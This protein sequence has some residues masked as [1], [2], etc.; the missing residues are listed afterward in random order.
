M[1]SR[2][3]K[4]RMGQL[5]KFRSAALKSTMF[6]FSQASN[7]HFSETTAMLNAAAYVYILPS[8]NLATTNVVLIFASSRTLPPMWRTINISDFCKHIN[9]ECEWNVHQIHTMFLN[10]GAQGC[11][12]IISRHFY[13][14]YTSGIH[15]FFFIGYVKLIEG[16]NF[17][18]QGQICNFYFQGRRRDA[19]F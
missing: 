5:T 1:S 8:H 10:S 17:F 15:T 14:S 19:F 11:C 12:R 3:S 4:T 13:H 2:T 9:L 6:R 18:F 16:H 7:T